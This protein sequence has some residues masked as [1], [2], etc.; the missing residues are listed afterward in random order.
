LETDALSEYPEKLCILVSQYSA[1]IQSAPCPLA[2][3]FAEMAE[4]AAFLYFGIGWQRFHM[5]VQI[6]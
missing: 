6:Q 5:S 1:L 2:E 4:F 3:G